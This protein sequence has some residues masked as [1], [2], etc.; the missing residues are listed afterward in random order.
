MDHSADR[1]QSNDDDPKDSKQTGDQEFIGTFL[2]G[3]VGGAEV[4]VDVKNAQEAIRWLVYVAAGAGTVRFISD[5]LRDTERT[6]VVAD[7]DAC[8]FL[9]RQCLWRLNLLVAGNALFSTRIQYRADLGPVGRKSDLT[10]LFDKADPFDV[11]LAGQ[12]VH[13]GL[14][15]FTIVS[16]HR[17]TG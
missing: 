9:C 7:D 1:P 11:S 2:V 17:L 12:C 16:K 5:G 14:D 3:L 8:P 4:E 10:T 6:M 15:R 13:R